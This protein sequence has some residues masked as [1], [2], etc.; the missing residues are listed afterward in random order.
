MSDLMDPHGPMG[1][2]KIVSRVA[3]AL[4]RGPQGGANVVAGIF[5]L[6]VLAIIIA[7]AIVFIV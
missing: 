2:P 4:G 5:A 6:S 3:E 1:V 7:L